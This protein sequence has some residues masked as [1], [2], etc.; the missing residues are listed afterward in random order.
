MLF[1]PSPLPLFGRVLECDLP[2]E[3]QTY[4][5]KV[6]SLLFCK[7]TVVIS[8]EVVKQ[9]NYLSEA[10]FHSQLNLLIFSFLAKGLA[11]TETAA[12]GGGG[13]PHF[14]LLSLRV[15]KQK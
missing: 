10:S 3:V 2:P 12:D 8:K 9:Q 1:F 5:L 7:E 13:K 6:S 15:K 14:L 4:T 11:R